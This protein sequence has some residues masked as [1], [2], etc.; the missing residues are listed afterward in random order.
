MLIEICTGGRLQT[1]L[2][3]TV[4]QRTKEA[5]LVHFNPPGRLQDKNISSAVA[6]A[7]RACQLIEQV[8][9]RDRRYEH[10]SEPLLW[11]IY[12]HRWS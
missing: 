1:A 7:S 12:H 2:D 6:Q 10:A 3:L 5:E 4:M 11:G 9:G 8:G